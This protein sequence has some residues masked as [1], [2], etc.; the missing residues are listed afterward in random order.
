[1]EFTLFSFAFAGKKTHY[2]LLGVASAAVPGTPLTVTQ[3]S[4]QGWA[5]E[6]NMGILGRWHLDLEKAEWLKR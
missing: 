3:A 1:M 5:D 6:E 4:T 2:F